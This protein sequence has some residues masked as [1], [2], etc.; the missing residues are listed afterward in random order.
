MK[1][2]TIGVIFYDSHSVH[3]DLDHDSRIAETSVAGVYQLELER[4]AKCGVRTIFFNRPTNFRTIFF[5]QLFEELFN[6]L[7]QVREC[8]EE[9]EPWLC[10][11]VRYPV[12]RLIQRVFHKTVARGLRLPEDEVIDI[13]CK[14]QVGAVM[15]RNAIN[16]QENM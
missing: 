15:G 16:F 3:H 8:T 2:L 12:L 13:K 11:L 6:C 10:L 14:P 5:G 1:A 4:L 7:F 9:G